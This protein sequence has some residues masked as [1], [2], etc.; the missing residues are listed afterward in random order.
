MIDKKH[1]ITYKTKLGLLKRGN[2][3]SLI[4]NV[5]LFKWK[6]YKKEW[7]IES[8]Y[9]TTSLEINLSTGMANNP[10][11]MFPVEGFQIDLDKCVWPN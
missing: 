9:E 7:Y 3:T 5:D 6:R 1:A 8:F 10:N 2:D 11:Y 4:W